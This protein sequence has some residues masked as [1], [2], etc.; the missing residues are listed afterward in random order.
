[1]AVIH[2]TTM[3]PS[4]LELVTAWLPTQPW[5]LGAEGEPQLTKVGGFRLDDPEGMV[6]IE[7]MAVTDSSGD[8]FVTYHLPLTYRG[9]PAG[10]DGLIGTSE[11]GVLGQRWIY[12]GTHD[13][14][15][16]TQIVALMQ[17]DAQA[18]AQSTSDTPDHTVV[19]HPIAAHS[20]MADGS[21]V[22]VNDAAGTEVRVRTSAG[23]LTIRFHRLLEPSDDATEDSSLGRVSA[24]WRLPDGAEV[25]G[26][27]ATARLSRSD[28]A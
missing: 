25:A 20:V 3:T 27:F 19:S 7:F 5:Y 10:G 15:L 1:M 6:G 14:V 28:A 16:V 13:R 21:A 9:A 26:T 2:Q 4:K 17:G 22:V 8:Q 18:Q 11:H 24:P 23:D 12:D